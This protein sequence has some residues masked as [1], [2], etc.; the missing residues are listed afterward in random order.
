[1]K[2][3]SSAVCNACYW[4]ASGPQSDKAAVSHIE[5]TGH[6]VTLGQG[7]GVPGSVDYD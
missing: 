1:M 4:T 2:E 6:S 7:L 3:T 5:E